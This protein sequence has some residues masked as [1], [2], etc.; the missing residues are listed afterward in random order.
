MTVKE[1]N[2]R[3]L[4]FLVI[5]ILLL[6]SLIICVYIVSGERDLIK[7]EADVIEVKE[8]TSSEDKNSIT[9]IYD[10][11]GI[12][13]EYAYVTKNEFAIDDKVSIYYHEDN[14]TS[15][16]TFKTNKIIFVCPV[17]GLILCIFGLFELFRKSNDE[18]DYK[19]A[20][21]DIVGNT[22][23]LEIISDAPVEE[24]VKTHEENVETSVKTIRKNKRGNS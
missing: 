15:V 20:V 14:P 1:T 22:Q 19:T 21:I 9:I 6:L 2:L 7:I 23:R 4:L 24:Y 11:N 5:G 12:Q 10:V 3:S 13:Y 17:L 8:D 16:Q 18:I